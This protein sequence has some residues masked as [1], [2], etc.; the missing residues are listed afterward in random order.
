MGKK[1]KSR[2]KEKARDLERCL[3]NEINALQSIGAKVK[4]RYGVVVG[5]GENEGHLEEKEG[6][7]TSLEDL[8]LSSPPTYLFPDASKICLLIASLLR[9][10]KGGDEGGHAKS[11]VKQAIWLEDVTT[12]GGEVLFKDR[13]DG[14]LKELEL[15]DVLD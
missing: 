10:R 14:L 12:G 1:G 2:G 3:A 4:G 7:I 9:L 11:W 15:V 5:S 13:F 6:K 8:P